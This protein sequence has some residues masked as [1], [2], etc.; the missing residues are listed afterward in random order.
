MLIHYGPNDVKFWRNFKN[1]EPFMQK[2]CWHAQ[3]P[4]PSQ[5][6]LSDPVTL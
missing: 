2:K 1:E 3:K 5:S 6:S 4:R